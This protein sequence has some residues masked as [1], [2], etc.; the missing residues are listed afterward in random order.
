MW[1]DEKRG[2]ARTR[3]QEIELGRQGDKEAKPAHSYALADGGA[4]EP[5][6]ELP[7]AAR[8]KL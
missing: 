7:E 2:Q 1:L 6:L 8:A 3:R 4:T 5:H